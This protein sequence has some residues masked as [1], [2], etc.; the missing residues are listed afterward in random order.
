MFSLNQMPSRDCFCMFLHFSTPVFE[1]NFQKGRL[2]KTFKEAI[3]DGQS[4]S[5]AMPYLQGF[6]ASAGLACLFPV[7]IC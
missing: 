5:K 6:Q 1:A 3:A 7:G 2:L 4:A